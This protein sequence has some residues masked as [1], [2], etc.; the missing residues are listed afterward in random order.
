VE[1]DGLFLALWS[2]LR[3][4]RFFVAIWFILRSFGTFFFSFW[5]VI[6]RKDLATL[7]CR[8]AISILF[9]ALATLASHPG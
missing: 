4:F 5:Y 2:I 7:V 8:K 9:Y 1:E 6:P 3:P